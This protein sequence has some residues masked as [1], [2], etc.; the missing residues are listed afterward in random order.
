MCM[1]HD[2]PD[3]AQLAR[4]N[5]FPDTSLEIS[6]VGGHGR[7]W[8][9]VRSARATGTPRT[10]TLRNLSLPAIHKHVKI[11]ENAGL[12]SRRKTGRTT[13]L[14]LN[15]QRLRLL[16]DWMGQFHTYWGSDQTSFENYRSYLDSDPQHR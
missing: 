15:P 9:G 4:W 7:C 8:H 1:S 13:Y 11:L 6:G 5:T 16:Q 14:V 2:S 12:V 3:P 10:G